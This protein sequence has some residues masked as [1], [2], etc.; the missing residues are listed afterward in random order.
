M[1]ILML[2]MPVY[3][4]I[5]ATLGFNPLWF[6][7]LYVVNMEMGL[8][9]PPFGFTLFYMKAVVPPEITMGDLYRCIWPFVALQALGLALV[10]IFPQ[11]AL[12]LPSLMIR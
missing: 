9:T 4:P 7:I 11:L 1:A 12:W 5:I 6:G 2:T 10:M 3:L 8:M